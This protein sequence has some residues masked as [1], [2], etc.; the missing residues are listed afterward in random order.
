MTTGRKGIFKTHYGVIEF[1]HTKKSVSDIISQVLRIEGRPLRVADKELAYEDF[2][3][4]EVEI[5]KW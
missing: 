1:T 4:V 2:K 3:N 5:F